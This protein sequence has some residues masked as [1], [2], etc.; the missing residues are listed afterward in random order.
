MPAKFTDWA[1]FSNWLES[2]GLFRMKP[3]LERMRQALAALDLQSPPFVTAQVLGTNGKGSTSAFLASI[4]K[5]HGCK[6]GLYTSP[7]FLTPRERITIN[8][9]QVNEEAW[10]WAAN[11]I[12]AATKAK[13]DLTYFEFLTVMALLIFRR[14][15]IQLAVLEAGLGGAGDATS[16]ILAQISLFT[17]IAMDHA[18]IIGPTIA[19]IA[20]DKCAVMSGTAVSAL[21]Y[22]EVC[23]IME[24]TARLLNSRLEFAQPLASSCL[25]HLGM[26][27]AHQCVNAGVA[28]AAWR[29]LAPLLQA[30]EN[31]CDLI[32]NGLSD[33]FMPGRLQ[34]IA[35]GT[36]QPAIILDGA[37]NPHGMRTL[38]LELTGQPPACIIFSCLADK[39]WRAS[40]AILARKL[41]DI[42]ILVVQLKNER[43]ADAAEVADFCNSI[44]PGRA[45][46]Y[47][48]NIPLQT[49]LAEA[50]RICAASRAP[51][52]IT[53]SL[54]MLSAFY[55][56]FPCHLHKI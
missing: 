10:L 44:H 51:V 3:G 14:E 7:H 11:E 43:A 33:A 45:H 24:Q 54:Y 28:V 8:G 55:E 2:L 27:G 16:A 26:E 31:N 4:A 39:D 50:R 22:P 1:Q 9:K 20:R 29:K 41:P 38:L 48:G 53:G 5:S 19:D 15:K 49:A 13:P 34:R 36:G 42:P 17:P 35:P 37:H 23:N 47:R 6:T 56:L 21:Q 46:A 12:F 32:K 40:L 25:Q 52:L 18:G 30:P